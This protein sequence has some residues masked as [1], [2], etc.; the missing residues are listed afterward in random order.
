[1]AEAYATPDDLAELFGKSREWIVEQCRRGE[2]VHLRV[3]IEYRFKPKHVEEIEQRMERR[4]RDA[5]SDGRLPGVS[6]RSRSKYAKAP[7]A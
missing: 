6:P 7:H 5:D 4:A 3:G 2:F 1:M